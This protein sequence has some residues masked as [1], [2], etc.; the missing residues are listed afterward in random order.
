MRKVLAVTIVALFLSGCAKKT[1]QE[2]APADDILLMRASA[3]LI[4]R[5]QKDLKSELMAA[6]NEGGA[7]HAITVCRVR[8]PEIA[9]AHSGE[10]WSIRRV[11]V[12]N[13][14]PNNLADYHHLGILAAFDDTTVVAPTHSYEWV[15]TAGD[16]TYRYYRPI[17]VMP[18]CLKCHGTD[19]DI[20]DA[21]RTALREKYPEDKATGYRPGDLRGM[22]VVEVKWPEGKPRAETL[23]SDTL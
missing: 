2:S 7:A 17:R 6:I 10:F 1:Q 22:F 4:D 12:K 14:N 19:A 9:A 8:A 18:L 21:T 16:S 20:D 11:T 5:F 15:E 3:K 23:A 13:R